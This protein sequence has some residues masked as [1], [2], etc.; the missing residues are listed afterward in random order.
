MKTILRIF[1]ILSIALAISGVTLVAVNASGTGTAQT[2]GV[3]GSGR[4]HFDSGTVPGAGQ[5][6]A[7]STHDSFGARGHEGN[8]S[9]FSLGETLKNIGIMAAF[10]LA[11]VLIER[12]VK[13][14]RG[15]RKAILV[16]VSNE[17]PDGKEWN[18]E[19]FI[20]KRT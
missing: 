8:G 4:G 2:A 19:P 18:S 10:I 5:P 15:V 6:P 12:L 3:G 9:L 14:T 7:G 13:K 11:V 16:Q 1:I 20:S 17:Q